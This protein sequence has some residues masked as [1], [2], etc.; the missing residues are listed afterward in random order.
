MT[1]PKRHLLMISHG[2]DVYAMEAAYA[3]LCAH[4]NGGFTGPIHVV[5]DHADRLRQLTG[6]APGVHYL[7][8][9]EDLKQSFIGPSGYV[10]RLKPQAI[11]WATRQIAAIDDALVFLDTD[12]AILSDIQPWFDHIAQGRGVLNECEG[13]AHAIANATRSQKRAGEFFKRG[14]LHVHGEDQPLHP[15]TPLWNS[16]VIG[17]KAQQVGWFDETTTWIDAIWPL[18]PIHTVEQLA[19]SAVLHAHRVPLVDSG[20]TVFHYHWF[21]EFRTDLAAFFEH[22]GTHAKY[23]ERIALS[24]SMRP[25]LRIA[26]KKDF[27]NKPKWLRSILRRIGR[28]W[29]PMPYPWQA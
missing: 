26:P 17:F 24:R 4:A 2:S 27:L 16:G 1:T 14:T 7:P 5:T 8:L 21:K 29:Q 19:F 6:D 9:S 22:L 11:A 13:P 15:E 12:T 20:E 18:L 25:D 3:I 28:N 23:A 10:H